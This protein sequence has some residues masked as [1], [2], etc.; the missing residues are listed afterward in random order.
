M[1]EKALPRLQERQREQIGLMN[2]QQKSQK[3][4]AG[5][6]HEREHRQGQ[7]LLVAFALISQQFFLSVRR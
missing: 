1:N 4:S 2:Q 6:I 3:D 7:Q 5:L